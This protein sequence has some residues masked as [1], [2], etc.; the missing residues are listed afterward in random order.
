MRAFA[1]FFLVLLGTFI[2]DQNIKFLFVE[3]V[4][5]CRRVYRP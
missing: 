2:I 1:V 4:L 5:S 3:G